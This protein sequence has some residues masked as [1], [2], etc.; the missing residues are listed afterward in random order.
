MARVHPPKRSDFAFQ[1]TLRAFPSLFEAFGRFQPE[2]PESPWNPG[3]LF[4]IDLSVPSTATRS[5][6][7]ERRFHASWPERS[8]EKGR[9]PEAQREPE[10]VRG[11]S[12]GLQFA[13]EVSPPL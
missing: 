13:F 7:R 3:S 4:L 9:I 1:T 2:T 5:P 10:H 12:K 11:T 8:R 6:S